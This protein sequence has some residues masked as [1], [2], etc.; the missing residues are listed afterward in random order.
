MPQSSVMDSIDTAE[1]ALSMPEVDP[2]RPSP[3]RIY[4]FWLGWIAE[5]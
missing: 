2:E 3:A 5:L 1:L 4:D